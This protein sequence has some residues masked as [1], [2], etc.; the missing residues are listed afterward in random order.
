MKLKIIN[1]NL[2]CT[3]H[4]IFGIDKSLSM[5]EYDVL[6][7]CEV[8]NRFKTQNKY[9]IVLYNQLFWCKDNGS[10]KIINNNIP[11]NWIFKEQ[12]KSKYT[13]NSSGVPYTQTT[14][15]RNLHCYQWMLDDIQF[16]TEILEC[17]QKA[18]DK[19]IINNT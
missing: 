8:K 12:F 15:L 11:T 3:T 4:G 7:M 2:F 6:A 16:F 13:I 18:Y 14:S 10:I 17:P 9:L 1:I 19:F 5:I